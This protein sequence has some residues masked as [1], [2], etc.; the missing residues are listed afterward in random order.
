MEVVRVRAARFED[1][2]K[3]EKHTKARLAEPSCQGSQ[4][5]G[6]QRQSVYLWI[7]P[8]VVS[9]LA[10]TAHCGYRLDLRSGSAFDVYSSCIVAS[11]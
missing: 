4:V 8:K 5:V 11:L 1:Q 2:A 6:G 9:S 7:L 10:L 3:E